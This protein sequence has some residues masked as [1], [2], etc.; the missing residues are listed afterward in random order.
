MDEHE[1]QQRLHRAVD[2]SAPDSAQL[3]EN[4]MDASEHARKVRNAKR[5]GIGLA[6]LAF[7]IG[8]PLAINLANNAPEEGDLVGPGGSD[9]PTATATPTLDPSYTSYVDTELNVTFPIPK[10]WEV[11]EFEGHRTVAPGY[12][13]APPQDGDTAF[14]SMTFGDLGPTDGREPTTFAGMP[15]E[16]VTEDRQ[17]WIVVAEWP[18][19]PFCDGCTG[20][21]S[22][23]SDA[24]TAS[25]L[26]NHQD[27]FDLIFDNLEPLYD[28]SGA[29]AEIDA[30]DL[31]A[32][33][34]TVS[35]T[36]SSV[37]IND[38][39]ITT[40]AFMDAR[41]WMN[42]VETYATQEAID[43]IGSEYAS[44]EPP[45]NGEWYIETFDVTAA[46]Q[47]DA[48]SWQI[49][50]ALTRVNYGRHP[51]DERRMVSIETLFVGPG[52]AA[53][54]TQRANVIRGAAITHGDAT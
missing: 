40:T 4:V 36:D 2:G 12:L 21:V 14:M 10:D 53:D 47:A 1:L 25:L 48:N 5:T 32:R 9:T 8:T 22:F 3:W 51:E 16:E 17:H 29:L 54:G 13:P 18:S 41:T 23:W 45:E 33:R 44:A 52:E 34:G 50:V 35:H 26:A 11:A 38:A 28:A 49:T 37:A 30:P 46:E 27:G 20:P 6:V 43:A 39:V 19:S 42:P 15:A 31:K 24:S 7:A